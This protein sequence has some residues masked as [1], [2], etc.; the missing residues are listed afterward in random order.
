MSEKHITVWVQHRA[1]RPYDDLQWYDP[2]T[3][4]RRCKSAE[5]CNPLDAESKRAALE[6]ELNHGLYKEASDMSWERFRKTFEDEYV[7]ARRPNTRRNYKD[8]LDQFEQQCHPKR[9]RGI[10][11]R[12][13]SAF[14]AALRKLPTRGREGMQPSSIAVRLQFLRTTLRWAVSQKM[15]PECPRFPRVKVPK[16]K[17]QPVP[18]ESFERLFAKAAGDP[19]MQ[20]YLLCGWLAGMR[21]SE[22]HLLEWEPNDQAPWIDPAHNRIVLPAAFAKSDEDQWVPLDAALRQALEALPR[23]GKRV[24]RFLA[25]DGHPICTDALSD[26]VTTLAKKAGVKLTMHSL[27]KGFGCYYAGKVPAQVLQKLM[28]HHSIRTTMDYYANVDQAAVEAVLSRTRVGDFNNSRTSS[29]TSQPEAPKDATKADS[30][31]PSQG[32][33]SAFS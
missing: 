3:G 30:P 24:F 23:Y 18:A 22:A 26:R 1:D 28:R 14:A 6:Y 15:L 9:L 16:K 10:D 27:R 7:A 32:E 31:S 19:E 13:V 33:S 4:K 12:T 8:T 25:A 11:E 20:A 21:L 5:T 29:R 2:V 17:P